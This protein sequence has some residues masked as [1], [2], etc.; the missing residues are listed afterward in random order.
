MRSDE[1]RFWDE[2]FRREG[3]IWGEGPSPTVKALVPR[4]SAGAL[5]LEVGFGYGRD[6][7]FLIGQGH[8]A[9]GVDLSPEARRR[10]EERLRR[11]GLRAERLLTGRFEDSDLPTGQFD[12]VYSHRM[13]HLLV[14]DGA[15]AR[16]AAQARRALR[17]GG[18]LCL[19]VRNADDRDPAEV[20]RVAEGVDEYV[21]RPGHWIRFW[22]DAALRQAF[23]N[24]FHIQAFERVCENES[25]GRPVPCHL[26][27]LVGRK[28]E[29]PGAGERPAP[30]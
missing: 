4:L 12:A 29:G 25:R 6:L 7:A 22:D 21:P 15:V 11:A 8:R 28:G 1:G 5:V 2:R 16:F 30:G 3:A 14:T 23:G 24:A 13:A 27:I 19:A 10:T 9:W 17:P 20:R 18:T 26:T